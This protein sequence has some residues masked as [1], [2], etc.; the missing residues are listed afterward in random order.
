MKKLL[1]MFVAT[2]GDEEQSLSAVDQAIANLPSTGGDAWSQFEQ[3]AA[4]KAKGRPLTDAI[5]AQPGPNLDEV[6]VKVDP[7][8]EGTPVNEFILPKRKPDGGWDFLPVYAAS[9]LVPGTFTAEQ[10]LEIIRSM[11]PELPIELRR[12]TVSASIGTLGKTL[13]VTPESIA[14]DAALK[15]AAIEDFQS[16]VD[17][18]FSE[19]ATKVTAAITSYEKKIAEMKLSIET[20]RGKATELKSACVAEIDLLDDVTEFFT[21]DTGASKYAAADQPQPE[22]TAVK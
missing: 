6:K 8:A 16:K 21:L 20:A 15:I 2:D 9:N 7:P 14:A 18:N 3:Q 12:K 4:A 13:G 1:G 10:A 19:Y 5:A 22:T 17:G 11:P